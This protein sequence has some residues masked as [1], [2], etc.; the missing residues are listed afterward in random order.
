MNR[1]GLIN[2][3]LLVLIVF[4]AHVALTSYAAHDYSG[5]GFGVIALIL[6]GFMNVVHDAEVN[7]VKKKYESKIDKF[8]DLVA[9]VERRHETLVAQ[10]VEYAGWVHATRQP[11]NET[12]KK[13]RVR[14]VTLVIE[15][16]EKGAST[17]VVT[18]NV[19]P[20]VIR[21]VIEAKLKAGKFDLKNGPVWQRELVAFIY[22]DKATPATP[23]D[24]PAA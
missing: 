4:F 5:V 12:M 6:I 18:K 14:L 11:T 20:E 9:A 8:E 24:T 3:G 17:W 15:A 22:A 13:I 16:L 21:D 19:L 7:H 1:Y 2:I 10:L 23:A